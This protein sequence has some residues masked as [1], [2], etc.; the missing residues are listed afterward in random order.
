MAHEQEFGVSYDD[1]EQ[2]VEVMRHAAREL[3]HGLH[4]LRLREFGLERLLFGHIDEIEDH[5]ARFAASWARI[6]LRHAFV[7]AEG[8]QFD[9]SATRIGRLGE[10]LD[11]VLL[12]GGID[13]FG[14]RACGKRAGVAEEF[15]K[16]PIGLGDAAC[17][18]RKRD[19]HRRI[20]EQR[21][22]RGDSGLHR[23]RDRRNGL[24]VADARRE[25]PCRLI[26]RQRLHGGREFE[27]RPKLHDLLARLT[28]GGAAG[29]AIEHSALRLA[30]QRKFGRRGHFAFADVCE[31]AIEVVAIE[32]RAIRARDR[33]GHACARGGVGDALGLDGTEIH[34]RPDRIKEYRRNRADA[35]EQGEARPAREIGCADRQAPARQCDHHEAQRRPAP[36]AGR[37][38]VSADKGRRTHNTPPLIRAYFAGKPHDIADDLRH[39]LVMLRRHGFVEFDRREQ[40]AGERRIFDDG[41]VIFFG[42]LANT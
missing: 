27:R 41:H 15:R 23:G 19:A 4:L 42:H 38:A 13:E 20:P 37:Q 30:R 21:R 12:V 11:D 32:H 26:V 33:P 25:P 14:K 2:V 22:Q 28:L 24:R 36:S 34:A 31:P 8:T 18:V 16:A 9:R 29:K 40:R 5:A 1:R 7:L 10:Q 3:A 6:K 35:R 39:S 17:T